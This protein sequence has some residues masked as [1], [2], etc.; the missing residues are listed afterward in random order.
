M[1]SLAVEAFTP[2]DQ[3]KEEAPITFEIKPLASLQL[4]EVMQDG[5]KFVD[6]GM[7]LTFKGLMLC[8]RYGLKDVDLINTMPSRYHAEV[9]TAV[10]KK[11]LL[12]EDERK[13]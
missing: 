2:K 3:K 11:A 7:S 1:K 6:G 5:T 12:S 10:W 8:L 13:N 9:G 4:T